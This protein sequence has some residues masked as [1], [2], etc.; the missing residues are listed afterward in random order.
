MMPPGIGSSG[1]TSRFRLPQ[2]RDHDRA[3]RAE[4]DRFGNTAIPLPATTPQT[5]H[6]AAV[7]LGPVAG[8]S[9]SSGRCQTVAEPTND[10]GGYFN[11]LHVGHVS[12]LDAAA[13]LGDRVI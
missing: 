13:A 4:R 11:P 9:G 1:G 3:R 2:R 12:L 6:P 7:V 8:V 5:S 10:S